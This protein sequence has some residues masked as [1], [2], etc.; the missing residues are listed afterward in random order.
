MIIYSGDS[1]YGPVVKNMSFI[2]NDKNQTPVVDKISTVIVASDFNEYAIDYKAG[3][4]GKYFTVTLNDSN[5]NPLAN[6]ILSLTLN[7]KTYSIA[8]DNNGIAK[9]Q[10]SLQKAGNYKITISFSGD[11]QYK[12]SSAVKMIKIIKKKT[13]IKAKNKKFKASK[14]IKRLKVTLTTI[15]G[16]SVN[17]KKY[18]KAGKKLTLKVRGKIYK[19]KINKKGKAT[20][21]I[22]KLN[23]KGTFKA[24]IRF[25]GDSIYKASRKTIKIK[26]K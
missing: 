12:G 21:K 5:G 14:K 22:K 20:F 1:V 9:L 25:K 26:I 16:S 19:V 3:E 24:K 2:V 17:G 11:D 23:K 15:K 10:I 7:G 4:R 13:K 6:K 18:L 8:T